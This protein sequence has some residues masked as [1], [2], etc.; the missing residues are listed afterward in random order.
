MDIK[1]VIMSEESD[2]AENSA[3]E[4]YLIFTIL[5][6]YYSLP[7]KLI[8]EITLYD[9]V[10]P[11]PLMPEYVP[12]IINRYSTPYALIDIGLFLRDTVTPRTK[13]LVLKE[14][15]D[16]AAILIEDVV[17]ITDI[18]SGNMLQIEQEADVNDMTSVITSFFLWNETN[19]FVLDI[20]KILNRIV[21]EAGV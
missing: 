19:V 3:G 9:T 10:Y 4:K 21:D 18:P 14:Q 1:G 15:V 20:R 13:V 6:K 5:G 12:G 16:K 8:G 2:N 7:S 17:D 11:L